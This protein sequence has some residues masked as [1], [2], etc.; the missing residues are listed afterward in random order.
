MLDGP[1]CLV[2]STL[3]EL[4]GTVGFLIAD[5]TA[6]TATTGNFYERG[7]KKSAVETCA[8]GED[9]WCLTIP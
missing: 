5:V 9:Y 2:A 7:I 6:C 1:G 3:K 8:V 4:D